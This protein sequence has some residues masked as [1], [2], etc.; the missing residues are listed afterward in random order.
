MISYL[1][2]ATANI[3]MAKGNKEDEINKVVK[4]RRLEISASVET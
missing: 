3:A 2:I 4:T 1:R